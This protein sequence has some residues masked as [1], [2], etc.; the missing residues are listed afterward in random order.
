MNKVKFITIAVISTLS[1][2]INSTSAMNNIKKENQKN[3][4]TNSVI[5]T[6]TNNINLN[7]INL[8]SADENKEKSTN[9]IQNKTTTIPSKHKINNNIN[10]NSINLNN[11]NE[12]K[13]KSNIKENLNKLENYIEKIIL[14]KIKKNQQI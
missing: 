13:E 12:N 14:I 2:C 3:L 1:I 7:S 4:K 6:N 11:A 8:N 5:T 9:L 10:L